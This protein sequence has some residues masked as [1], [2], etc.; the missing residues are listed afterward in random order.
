MQ[1]KNMKRSEWDEYVL[2]FQEKTLQKQ[3][4]CLW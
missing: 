2:I 1:S 3:V 4:A